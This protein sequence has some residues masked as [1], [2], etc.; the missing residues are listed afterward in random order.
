MIFTPHMVE[1]SEISTDQVIAVGY[2]NHHERMYKFSNFLP[3]SSDQA[4]HS[5]A[6][7]VSK[8]WNERFG[9]M[10]YRYLQA[11][12]RDEM[13]EGLPQIKSSTGACIGCVVGKYP[14]QSYEK[15]KARRE[16]QT[17]GLVHSDLIG[18]LPTLSYGGFRYVITFID[19]YSQ[20]YWVYF[21][22][23][24]SEVFE[25]LNVWKALVEN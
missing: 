14:E 23:L 2:A 19:D 17:I 15:G 25:K 12:H 11:L 3:T 8:L 9:H 20:F 10:N 4:L 18:P 16:T 22:K 24:K 21:M 7:E 1:I 13:V 6:N 5:H